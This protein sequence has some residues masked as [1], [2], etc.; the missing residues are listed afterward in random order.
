MEIMTK[1]LQILLTNSNLFPGI[2]LCYLPV[3][4]H[5]R[6]KKSA[7]YTIA[8]VMG[9][10]CLILSS[11]LLLQTEI[12]S[13]MVGLPLFTICFFIYWFT[14]DIP[15]EKA[16]AVYLM[17]ISL[18]SFSQ[19][20]SYAI[21][22]LWHPFGSYTEF[23]W[24]TAVSSF[25][26]SYLIM[27]V[28]WYPFSRQ[29]SWLIDHLSLRKTW[30]FLCFWALLFTALLILLIPEN[31]NVLFINRLY[32]LNYIVLT[33]LLLV[34]LYLYHMIYQIS[35]FLYEK[36]ELERQ[37]QF[38]N[39]QAVK[40]NSLRTNMEKDRRMRH[41][42]R[43]HLLVLRGLAL[44][45]DLT[46]LTNYLES[47]THTFD[48]SSEIYCSNAAVDAIASY[49]NQ[50]AK[51]AGI[52]A[53]WSLQLPASLPL[54][55]TDFCSMLGNL[56]ENAIDACQNA[57]ES[58]RNLRVISHMPTTSMLILLIENT[59]HNEIIEKD[60][61]FYSTKHDG[62]GIGLSSVEQ[63]VHYYHGNMEVNYE[64]NLFQVQIL[65]NL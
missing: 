1:Y 51:D 21:G 40:Y 5:I 33:F 54:K 64:N 22:S 4:E 48:P 52:T 61:L 43:Q 53:Y 56:L 62:I 44:K 45:Q 60:A 30:I 12:S 50:I 28:A 59:F 3:R 11:F 20:Y 24:E 65:L 32:Y 19:N 38:L 31:F 14:L 46:G 16:L 57:P 7:V 63:M 2:I 9:I 41:D 10:F 49:Y 27:A 37:N 55:E 15:V 47:Y 13:N 34:M 35:R 23:Y 8:T 26:I 36:A 25:F 29:L 6:F 58:N 18:L 39:F 42:F 17:T